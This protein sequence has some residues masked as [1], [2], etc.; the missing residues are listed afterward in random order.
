M[1]TMG[2]KGVMVYRPIEGKD[3]R[4]VFSIDSFADKVVDAVGAGDA[5]LSYA[6]LALLTSGSE[7]AASIL[8]SFAAALATEREGNNPIDPKA[9]LEKVNSIEKISSFD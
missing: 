5:F 8:G 7:T 3:E 4:A 1:M 2:E 9:V 6:T